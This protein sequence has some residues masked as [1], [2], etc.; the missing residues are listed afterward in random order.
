[1]RLI[2]VFPRARLAE[3]WADDTLST[4]KIAR[5]LSEETGL[6][7]T[8]NAVVGQ[9]HR[10]KL[11]KREPPISTLVVSRAKQAVRM[12]KKEKMDAAK[13]LTGCRF[14]KGD[15]FVDM[16][17]AGGD[18]YCGKPTVSPGS[19]WCHEHKAIVSSRT[20]FVC[21]ECAHSFTTM[22]GLRIHFGKEHPKQMAALR[23]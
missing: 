19:S 23:G 11:P 2:R 10:M 12:A 22:T 4:Q 15:N 16:I 21:P 3:L 9:A 18:P 7:I 14:I 17:R 1:M 20:T 6:E 13:P 8:K 5:V